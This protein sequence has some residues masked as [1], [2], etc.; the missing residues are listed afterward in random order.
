MSQNHRILLVGHAEQRRSAAFE[1][2]AALAMASSAPLHITVL[3]EPFMT[4]PLLAAELREQI[5][6]SLLNEQQKGWSKEVE[7]LKEKGIDATFSVVWTDDP[8][9]EIIRHVQEMQPDLLVKDIQREPVLKRAFVT[10]LDWC[11]LRE[12]PVP[13]HLVNDARHPR[14]QVVVAAVDPTDPEAQYSGLND[15]I[16]TA[17]AGLATQCSAEFQ[18]LYVYSNIPAYM[19]SAGDTVAGW[20]D[21]VEELR[22]ALHQ[23]F[24]DLAE[25]HGVPPER[26]H[27]M[28]GH[29]V[30]GITEF[31]EEQQADVVVMGRV[32]R[33]VLDNLIGSTTETVL[34]RLSGSVLA[35]QPKERYAGP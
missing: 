8:H 11:L 33:K 17:G 20:A 16:I 23:S 21:V 7:R 10:P 1:R 13:L 28:V 9:E 15:Q 24:V 5:R 26:R 35:I 3:V 25:Q 19:T 29:P 12:C 22:S 34:Y 27:F 32:H 2:A 4:F 31:A 6:K 18:L 30:T 14:P